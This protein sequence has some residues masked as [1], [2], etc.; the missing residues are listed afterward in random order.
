MRASLQN[1]SNSFYLLIQDFNVEGNVIKKMLML[2]LLTG[3]LN[4]FKTTAGM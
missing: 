1:P 4:L 2:A 3:T